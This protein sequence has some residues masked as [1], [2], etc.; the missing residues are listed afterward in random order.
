MFFHNNHLS[1]YYANQIPWSKEYMT[2]VVEL[3]LLLQLRKRAFSAF[4]EA[5]PLQ[6]E[7][8]VWLKYIIQPVQKQQLDAFLICRA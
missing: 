3:E 7:G 8:K 1:S 6:S 5:A 2:A 4:R